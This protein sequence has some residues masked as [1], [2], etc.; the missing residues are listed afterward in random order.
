MQNNNLTK[1]EIDM[2]NMKIL[3]WNLQT[4]G[5]S[6]YTGKDR[7]VCNFVARVIADKRADVLVI[8]ELMEDGQFD[9][10]MLATY[11]RWTTGSDWSYDWLPGAIVSGTLPAKILNFNDLKFNGT[12]HNEG[13]AVLYKK[14]A[15]HP[16]TPTLVAFGHPGMSKEGD[17]GNE[18]FISLVTHGAQVTS[19]V[20]LAMPLIPAPGPYVR[21]PL[22]FAI[23]NPA[24]VFD[25]DPT[26]R[27]NQSGVDGVL[28]YDDVR[29]PCWVKLNTGATL[30]H[31]VVYHA[32][33]S[34][35]GSYNGTGICGLIEQVQDPANFPNVIVAGDFNN[36]VQNH[37]N[38]GFENFTQENFN[39][40]TG[41]PINGFEKSMTRFTVN[42]WGA[43]LLQ[44][45]DPQANFYGNPRDQLLYRFNSPGITHN[46]SEVIDIVSLLLIPN[47]PLAQYVHKSNDISNFIHRNTS[48]NLPPVV[49]ASANLVASL[50][51]ICNPSNNVP[52][53]DHLTAATFYRL[54]ISDHFPVFIDFDF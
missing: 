37:L 38:N 39:Y 49:S 13:Y 29:R 44:P 10:A 36:I 19:D 7:V 18:P 52:F 41:D 4:F 16:Y 12:A 33:V 21:T 26:R 5:K 6:T 22:P 46:S 48:Y 28:S 11:L 27:Y 54:F 3:V 1:G 15:H 50:N 35:F 30:V 32:P 20:S 42:N 53:P 25:P 17:K 31:L 23:P 8:Q 43:T 51:N 40:G 45:T 34:Y 24:S 47:S 14:P 2:G 9:L